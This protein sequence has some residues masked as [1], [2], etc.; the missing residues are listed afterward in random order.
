VLRGRT[1]AISWL[2]ERAGAGASIRKPAAGEVHIWEESL[3]VESA[4]LGEFEQYLSPDEHLKAAHFRFPVH[5]SRFIAGRGLLRSILARYLSCSPAELI[6]NYSDL[7][8]PY[9]GDERQP[10]IHFNVA[11]SE[12]RFI[13]AIAVRAVGIDIEKI[14][15][16]DRMELDSLAELVFS[17]DELAE[18]SS[19]TALDRSIPFLTLWT[20]KEALLKGIGLGIAHHLKN[21]SV[22]FET[23]GDAIIRGELTSER[24]SVQT[25]ARE[26]VIWSVAVP[27][28]RANIRLLRFGVV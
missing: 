19:I 9:I 21:V 22:F 1:N 8:K 17:P 5:R 25:V 10:P 7:G 18:W 2:P 14:G 13:L 27:F 15:L 12:D 11:H 23:Q 24:W 28:Q 20:R 16:S 26:R 3:D 6:F 4:R